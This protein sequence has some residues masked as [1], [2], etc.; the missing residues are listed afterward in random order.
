MLP[1]AWIP[2]KV[3]ENTAEQRIK[4]INEHLDLELNDRDNTLR[5]ESK[6]FWWQNKIY[7]H[8][9]CEIQR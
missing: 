8:Q 7:N 5:K 1:I 9:T 2:V 3:Q 6:K 4:A